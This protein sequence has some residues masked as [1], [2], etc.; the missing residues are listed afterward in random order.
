L[1]G[2][3]VF[4]FY[5][6]QFFL[7]ILLALYFLSVILFLTALPAYQREYET[8]VKMAPY[9]EKNTY[10]EVYLLQHSDRMVYPSFIKFYQPQTQYIKIND[11]KMASQVIKN[12]NP[13]KT[14][15]VIIEGDIDGVPNLRKLPE[16]RFKFLTIT[17]LSK[18]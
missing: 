7:N 15:A 13:Q 5:R 2:L 6:R 12:L 4:Q 1:A 3:I 18:P 17:F 8:Y 11:R 9:F 16:Y 10:Q 14:Y